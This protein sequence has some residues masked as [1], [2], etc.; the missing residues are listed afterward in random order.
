MKVGPAF[1]FRV[2]Q[3]I[4][5]KRRYNKYIYMLMIRFT[6]CATKLSTIT[7]L[8]FSIPSLAVSLVFLQYH[9]FPLP[10]EILRFK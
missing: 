4:N 3:F 1:G 9:N 7:I 8:I 10:A 2:N 6:D 5:F